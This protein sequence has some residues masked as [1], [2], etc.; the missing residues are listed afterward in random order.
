MIIQV[1]D[2]EIERSIL[3][4]C[5]LIQRSVNRFD[6]GEVG[7]LP[8]LGELRRERWDLPNKPPLWADHLGK[9]RGIISAARPDIG[10]FVPGFDA[11]EFQHFVRLARRVQRTLFTWPLR[12]RRG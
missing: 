7:I 6:V 5:Y 9:D 2:H 11:V 3:R 4:Q 12:I 10:Y 1:N 8:A